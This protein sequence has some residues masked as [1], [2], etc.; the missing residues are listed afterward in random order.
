MLSFTKIN[1]DSVPIAYVTCGEKK[2]NVI[3][4]T[5]E[6]ID[7]VP[8]EMKEKVKNFEDVID[9]TSLQKQYKKTFGKNI[10]LNALDYKIINNCIEQN[11]EPDDP[12]LQNICSL[13][14]KKMK[15]DATTSIQVDDGFVMF[16]PPL[17]KSFR[18]YV[19]GPAGSG[20]SVMCGKI[21]AEYARNR[22]DKNIYVFSDVNED[23]ALDKYNPIRV[24]LNQEVADNPITINDIP[25]SSLILFDDV[26]AIPDKKIK[27]SIN[28]LQNVILR[29]GRHP[30]NYP[31]GGIA[32][33]SCICTAHNLTN[34]SE[35]RIIL[36]ESNFIV[37]FP[38]STC[39]ANLQYVL[40]KY[41]NMSNEDVNKLCSI[42]TRWAIVQRQF[43]SYV[44][45]QSGVY[46]YGPCLTIQ[47]NGAGFN[48]ALNATNPA[49]NRVYSLPDAGAD[50]DIVLTEG[51]QTINGAKVLSGT[52]NI[53][54][55]T[56]AVL[57]TN[58]IVSK[59]GSDITID[60]VGDQRI[61]FGTLSNFGTRFTT[62]ASNNWAAEFRNNTG[63]YM[64]VAGTYEQ[65]GDQRP[66]IG[67]HQISPLAWDVLWLNPVSAVNTYV[68]I[69]DQTRANVIAK[70]SK[71][72]VEGSIYSSSPLLSGS[73]LT[74]RQNGANGH[75]LTSA[76]AP[77]SAY[78]HF[79]QPKTGTLC[80]VDQ[81]IINMGLAADFTTASATYVRATNFLFAGTNNLGDFMTNL[82]VA[83]SASGGF[84]VSIRLQDVTNSLTI[85]ESAGFAS[86]GS[87]QILTLSSFSNLPSG[88]AIFELQCST[89]TAPNITIHAASLQL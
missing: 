36:N 19:A 87:N 26:D 30:P 41:Y 15:T 72:Y 89:T 1:K 62:T 5:V 13:T 79:L 35:T 80:D 77:S 31:N 45:T 50:A 34:Y 76:V 8:N 37:V 3:W 56:G 14:R 32:E 22:P 75:I 17:K 78:N 82:F 23:E 2:N 71:L 49:A 47:P 54:M 33:I 86:G 65:G 88:P 27:K 63:N 70:G 7:K 44:I 67:G 18:M 61:N 84:L 55:N 85:A 4:L 57:E 20:K 53:T 38:R 66:Q 74:I 58:D 21:I 52:G 39:K 83:Y 60:A 48:V 11:T 69:G 68:C 43:P 40:T 29:T 16:I 51:A 64:V 42:P 73:S 24:L 28:T 9:F 81:R 46:L 10:R 6:N 59:T 12:R 25:P